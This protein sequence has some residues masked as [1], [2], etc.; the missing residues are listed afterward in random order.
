MTRVMEFTAR[1]LDHEAIG[2]HL[3]DSAGEERLGKINRIMHEKDQVTVLVYLE[4]KPQAYALKPDDL[5][6]IR[7]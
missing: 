5:V 3:M 1:A 2:T 7:R 6:T 4:G